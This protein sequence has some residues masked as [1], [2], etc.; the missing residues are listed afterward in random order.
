MVTVR[1]SDHPAIPR[2]VT[3]ICLHFLR[4]SAR[5]NK[6]IDLIAL[7]NSQPMVLPTVLYRRYTFKDCQP[8]VFLLH[9]EYAFWSYVYKKKILKVGETMWKN[10]LKMPLWHELL[11]ET[12]IFSGGWKERFSGFVL[13]FILPLS[14]HVLSGNLQEGTIAVVVILVPSLPCSRL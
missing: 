7:Q 9:P 11:T 3:E 2:I 13:G 8:S 14:F 1:I 10:V 5:V 6:T 4:R 12:G